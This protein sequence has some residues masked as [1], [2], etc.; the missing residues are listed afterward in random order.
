[1]STISPAGNPTFDWT[2]TDLRADPLVYPV[3]TVSQLE[4]VGIALTLH[5]DTSPSRLDC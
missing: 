5:T 1:M 2:W 3:M 4:L